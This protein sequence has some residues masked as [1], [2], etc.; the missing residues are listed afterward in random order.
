MRKEK[1]PSPSPDV[2]RTEKKSDSD[3]TKRITPSKETEIQK[4]LLSLASRFVDL[5]WEILPSYLVLSI[6]EHL[7]RTFVKSY[8]LLYV[9]LI[10]SW[11]LNWG[12]HV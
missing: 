9:L 2:E 8:R 5:I 1:T 10:P 3:K 7:T 12:V 6:I 11:T 4:S